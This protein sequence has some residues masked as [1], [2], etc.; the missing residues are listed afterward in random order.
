MGLRPYRNYK[1]LKQP[2]RLPDGST[3]LRPYR[4]YKVLKRAGGEGGDS[5]V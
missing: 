1:V 4:N 2:M 5:G 3:S